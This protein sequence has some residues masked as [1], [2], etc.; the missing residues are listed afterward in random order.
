MPVYEYTAKNRTGHIFKGSYEDTKSISSLRDE[1][2]KMGYELLKVNRE[3]NVAKKKRIKQT[4]VVAFIYQLAGMCSAGLSISKSLQ[5]LEDQIINHSFKNVITEIRRD[6]E[7]GTSLKKAFEKHKKIFSD[8]IL[9]M[10]EAGESTGKLSEALNMSAEYLEKRM[11]LNR[12]VRSAFIYPIFVGSVCLVVLT[13]L[14]I[15]VVP[16]FAKIYAQLHVTLPGPTLVLVGLSSL[17]RH[18]WWAILI[19]LFAAIMTSRS[20]LKSPLLRKKWDI[21]KLE[22]PVFG[23]LNHLVVVSHFTRTFAMLESVG[24]SIIDSLNVANAVAHNYKMSEIVKELKLAI[25]AGNPIG[26]TMKKYDI[27]PPMVTQLAISGEE[28]GILSQ[29]LLKSADFIDKD[30]DRVTQALLVKLEPALTVVMGVIVGSILMAVYLPM[31][32]YMTH[33]K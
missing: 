6:I 22:M 19:V 17:I 33:L 30:I 28:A 10:I 29:M 5:T 25:K 32:D 7:A 4:E 1:M 11:D 26:S 27:F 8:F 9:G 12:K 3:E 14:L 23:Q 21:F 2:N 15:F 31:F 13:G 18:W 16:V 24:V 20:F